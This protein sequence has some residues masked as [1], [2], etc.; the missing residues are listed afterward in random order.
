MED[1]LDKISQGNK[2]WYELCK[3]CNDQISIL[4]DNLKLC[5][6]NPQFASTQ[7]HVASHNFA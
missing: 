3:D 2:I 6:M 1:D 5:F 7:T 4:M